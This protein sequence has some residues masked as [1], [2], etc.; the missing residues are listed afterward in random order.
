MDS[1]KLKSLFMGGIELNEVEITPF[2]MDEQDQ[3]FEG[4]W[5]TCEWTGDLCVTAESEIPTDFVYASSEMSI[6][7]GKRRFT[8]KKKRHRK[9]IAKK[10]TR[11]LR[12]VKAIDFNGN[13]VTFEAEML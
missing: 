12:D 10:Y 5:K 13:E 4:R 2:G 9:K 3:D 8:S 11:T 7:F 1:H 6:K